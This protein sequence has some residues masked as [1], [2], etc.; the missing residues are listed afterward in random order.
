MR[1]TV[2]LIAMMCLLVPTS[3]TYAFS[4][5]SQDCAK[6]HTLTKDEASTLLKDL[7]PNLK[8]L[9]VRV[10]PLKA[11]WEVD[12]QA[13][14]KKGLVYVDFSKQYLVSGALVDIKEKKN[15]SQM[16]LSEINKVDVSTIPLD[17]AIVMGDKDAKYRVIVF[18]D[19]A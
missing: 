13:N 7:I 2:F 18:S 11:L 9:D 16:R 5:S 10:S 12:L 19:P 15:V 17:D 4:P 6:C 8:I 3:Y 1:K 14:G